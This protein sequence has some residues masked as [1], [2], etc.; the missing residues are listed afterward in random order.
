VHGIGAGK[1]KKT[2]REV[3]LEE[4]EQVVPWKALL[5]VIEPHYPLAGR[6]RRPYPLESMLRVHLMQNWF[7][8]SESKRPLR[9]SSALTCLKREG[10]T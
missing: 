7:A 10:R 9:A 1:R 5:K 6:G 3:F 8:L 4:M 2:R